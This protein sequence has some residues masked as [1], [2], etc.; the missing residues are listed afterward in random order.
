MS[1]EEDDRCF[2][3]TEVRLLCT[4]GRKRETEQ[5]VAALCSDGIQAQ[6]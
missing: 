1:Q 2:G 4:Q 6:H 5:G 3:Y